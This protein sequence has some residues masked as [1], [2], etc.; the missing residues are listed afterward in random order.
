MINITDIS[1]AIFTEL[2]SCKKPVAV[3]TEANVLVIKVGNADTRI[4]N[5]QTMPVHSILDIA[6][7]LTLKENFNGNILLHG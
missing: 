6:K 4:M 7:S 1:D 3:H 5:W 2:A